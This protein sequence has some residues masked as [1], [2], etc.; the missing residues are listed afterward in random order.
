MQTIEVDELKRI[1]VDVLSAAH[2]FC[3]ENGIMYSLACGTL[4]G[5]IRHN[6]YI[7]WDDDIDI[8]MKRPDYERF[9]KSFP[10][11]YKE[12][13]KLVSIERNENWYRLYANL[14]DD[15]TICREHKVNDEI[16]IGAK[17]DIFP[18]DNVPDKKIKWKLFDIIRR[19]LIYISSAKRIDVRSEHRSFYRQFFVALF[20]VLLLPIPSRKLLLWVDSYCQVN[21]KS[22][23]KRLFEN[24]CG[25]I[26]KNP[27]KREDFDRVALHCFENKEFCIMEGFDDYLR[28]GFGDYMKLPPE[29]KRVSNHHFDAYWK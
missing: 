20:K 24:V 19:M 6:G 29:H 14:Y 3:M 7:P 9:I 27:F 22:E 11:A 17:I 21:N 18:V 23:T 4:L 1:Q 15:R 13:Y 28:N 5:A 16:Q 26:Q 25:I 10:Q 2:D 12:H 8:Y